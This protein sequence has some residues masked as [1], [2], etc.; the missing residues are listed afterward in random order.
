M[1]SDKEL[2]M[3]QKGCE[4]GRLNRVKIEGLTEDLK[5]MDDKIMKRFDKMEETHVDLFNHKSH[6]W[7]PLAVFIVS[8]AC[9][10]VGSIITGVVVKTIVG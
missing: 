9:T 8:I 1:A 10:L 3:T 2:T 7:P 6:H 4:Y 5:Q